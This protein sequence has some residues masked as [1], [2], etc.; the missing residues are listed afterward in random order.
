MTTTASLSSGN[1]YDSNNLVLKN[2]KA[3]D[4]PYKI[5]PNN[6]SNDSNSLGRESGASP[7]I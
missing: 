5:N 6:N 2:I 3:K 7:S 1:V 4:F